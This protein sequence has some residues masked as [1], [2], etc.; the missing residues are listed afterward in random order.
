VRDDVVMLK[1][2]T[3]RSTRGR[4]RGRLV[5]QQCHKAALERLGPALASL[6]FMLVW[7]QPAQARACPDCTIGRVARNL[8]W[9]DDFAFNLLVAAAPFTLVIAA[10]V[11]AE[12]L[13]RPRSTRR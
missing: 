13:G 12:R 9:H 1:S 10:S 7:M 11:W 6:W 2:L 8:V 3:Q 5:R 4:Q